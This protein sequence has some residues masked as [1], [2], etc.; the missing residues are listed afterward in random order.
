MV[1]ALAMYRQVLRLYRQ[2]A[3]GERAR[4]GL[5]GAYFETNPR[6]YL[7]LLHFI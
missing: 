6:V 1:Y 3:P 7:I 5:S 4:M 2:G